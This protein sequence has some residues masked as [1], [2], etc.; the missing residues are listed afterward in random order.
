MGLVG[1]SA[2]GCLAAL[3]ALG[4]DH[5]TSEYRGDAYANT[6]SDV[7]VVIGF[8]GIYDMLAQWQHDVLAQSKREN[9]AERNSDRIVRPPDNIT[10]AFLG[11]A[12]EQNH[13]RYLESSPISY[14]TMGRTG[15]RPP[16]RFLIISGD[17]DTLVD[18]QSQ[19]DAFSAALTQ[20]GFVAQRIVVPGA[21]HFW[22]SDPLIGRHS[23]PAIATPKVLRFLENYL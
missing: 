7:K 20:A 21:G 19:S 9:L 10:Q 3:L 16:P 13:A 12:P 2:G 23:F 6:Q 5:F 11:V 22:V 18:A 1:D 17:R 4:G 14:I 15:D 8:Y